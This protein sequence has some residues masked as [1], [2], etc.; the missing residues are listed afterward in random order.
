MEERGHGNAG[1]QGFWVGDPLSQP[2]R[3]SPGSNATEGRSV[4]R[5]IGHAAL[6]GVTVRAPEFSK[7]IAA[8]SQLVGG[9][10]VGI[11][12]VAE[13]AHGNGIEGNLFAGPIHSHQ[14]F[15]GFGSRV[16]GQDFVGPLVESDL[17]ALDPS[18]AFAVGIEDHR[19]INGN[20]EVAGEE[21]ME[22]VLA[23]KVD[24]QLTRPG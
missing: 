12:R 19:I 11:G 15:T 14:G 8:S 22:G 20:L 4:G 6:G 17:R 13:G 3:V 18:R 10:D 21:P 1:S 9:G 5:E 7:Q 23:A 24:G 16:F 2:R